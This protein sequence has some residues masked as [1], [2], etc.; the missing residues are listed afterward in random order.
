MA[1]KK[2]VGERVST[3]LSIAGLDP[4]GGAGVISDIRTFEHLGVYGMGIAAT[5]TFQN[6]FGLKGRFAPG[7]D[8]IRRQ[9]DVLLSDCRPDAIKI[10]ALGD[11]LSEDLIHTLQGLYDGPVV[12]DPVLRSTSGGDLAGGDCRE[13]LLKNLIPRATITVPNAEEVSD[14][15]DL[16]AE[17]PDEMKAAARR[18]IESGA[19]AVLITGGKF[20]TE[21]GTT[22]LDLY[23][24]GEIELVFETPWRKELKV[25]GTGCVISSAIAAYLALGEKL[26]LAVKRGR[27]VVQYAIGNAVTVGGGMPC[28]NTAGFPSSANR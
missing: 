7:K 3:A 27:E 17:T 26:P 1:G 24:D 9:L 8:V 20:E 11:S 14:L 6:T 4:C 2:E 25:H 5:L 19:N 21:K 22:A 15:W 16:E 13:L 28:A 23:N 18:I 10:G 12:V